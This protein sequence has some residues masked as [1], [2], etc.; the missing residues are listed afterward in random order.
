MQFHEQLKKMFFPRLA[1]SI[2]MIIELKS[3]QSSWWVI[4]ADQQSLEGA[5]PYISDTAD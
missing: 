2:S 3:E 4:E 5:P 1:V